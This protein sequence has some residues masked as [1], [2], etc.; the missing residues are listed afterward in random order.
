VYLVGGVFNCEVGLLLAELGR[1][2]HIKDTNI[3][4]YFE[5]FTW[6]RWLKGASGK[7]VLEKRSSGQTD[8][9]CSASEALSSYKL[10]RLF[11]MDVIMP[12]ANARLQQC[13]NSFFL[14]CEV[15]DLL[16][17]VSRGTTSHIQLHNCVVRHLE[18][19]K[20]TYGANEF[21]PKM[22][23]ATHLGMMLERHGTLISCF[24]HERKHKEVKWF[25]N[26]LQNT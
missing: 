9:K 17:R 22:H 26:N 8:L 14:I 10:L 4:T 24:V 15:L 21:F 18:L 2:A 13:C 20:A 1:E 6:P 12:T 23:W 3:H 19:F 16:V 11:L 25:G 5:E 7:K